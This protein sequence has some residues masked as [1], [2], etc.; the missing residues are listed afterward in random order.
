MET[1]WFPAVQLHEDLPRQLEGLLPLFD[2]G[3]TLS[4]GDSECCQIAKKV[5]VL[6][7]ITHTQEHDE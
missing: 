4:S 7:A 6:G 1:F 2:C 3:S 5:Q